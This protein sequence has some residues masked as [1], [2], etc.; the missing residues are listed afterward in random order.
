MVKQAVPV[1]KVLSATTSVMGF[2]V[3]L[4]I[5]MFV[6][7]KFYKLPAKQAF[8]I[9]LSWTVI[10]FLIAN[11]VTPR[12]NPLIANLIFSFYPVSSVGG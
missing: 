1:T 9:I 5:N 11:A 12:L 8:Y 6:A 4:G 3:I 10:A 7:K 2:I